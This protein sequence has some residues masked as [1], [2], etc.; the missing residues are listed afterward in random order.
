MRSLV[1]NWSTC[2]RQLPSYG[3][4]VWGDA[5]SDGPGFS[6][7]LYWKIPA[8]VHEVSE[9]SLWQRGAIPVADMLPSRS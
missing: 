2:E 1:T 5:S 8:S 4:S 9:P 3:P 7:V 6:L